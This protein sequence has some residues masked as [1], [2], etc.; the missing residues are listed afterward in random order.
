[1]SSEQFTSCL[2]RLH[3]NGLNIK[4]KLDGLMNNINVWFTL[5]YELRS[6]LFIAGYRNFDSKALNNRFE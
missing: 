2:V 5:I 1:M 3:I 6:I 4:Q